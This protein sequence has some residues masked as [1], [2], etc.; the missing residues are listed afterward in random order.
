MF[1]KLGL[2]GKLQCSTTGSFDTH[3]Y[4]LAT[5]NAIQYL[6]IEVKYNH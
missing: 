1:D 5:F 3:T 6:P 4:T 2:E